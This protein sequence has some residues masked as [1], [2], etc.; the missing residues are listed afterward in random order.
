MRSLFPLVLI[1]AAM[2]AVTPAA[3]QWSFGPQISGLGVGGSVTRKTFFR[4]VSVSAEFG[5]APVG[6]TTVTFEGVEYMLEPT[7]AGGLVMA[8]LHPFRSNFSV[9]AGYLLG[10]YSSNAMTPEGAGAYVLNGQ[11]YLVEDYGALQGTMELTG[12]VPAFM[13]GWRGSGFNFGLGV[14]LTDPAVSL[15]AAGPMSGSVNYRADLAQERLDL[16][17][18]LQVGIFGLKGIPMIRLG[19]ELGL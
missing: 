6:T 9:G 10:G 18:A 12:P 5:L 11:T 15:D 7:V 4:F 8:N 13:V 2:F 1:V 3:A 17:N 19:W 16:E 14:A